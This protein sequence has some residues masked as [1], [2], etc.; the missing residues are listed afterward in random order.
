MNQTDNV[1]VVSD[2]LKED[3]KFCGVCGYESVS[4]DDICPICNGKMAS[5]SEEA[6]SIDLKPKSDIFDDEI[7]LDQLAE[8]EASGEV[9][10]ESKTDEDL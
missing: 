8:E 5:L 9:V 2:P 6:D 10:G 1:A 7:T 4:E 3:V